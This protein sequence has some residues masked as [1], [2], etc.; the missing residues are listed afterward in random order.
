MHIVLMTIFA[1]S[2]SPSVNNPIVEQI[3]VKY[4]CQ[5]IDMSDLSQSAHPE[6]HCNV[7]NPH[8]GKAGNIYIASRIANLLREYFAREPLRCEFGYSSRKN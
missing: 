3:A 7:N 8:F 2:P 5:L 6:L 1:G 4:G